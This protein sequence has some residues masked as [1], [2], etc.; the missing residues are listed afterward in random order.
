M[1]DQ[2]IGARWRGLYADACRSHALTGWVVTWDPPEYP[3]QGC[4]PPGDEGFHPYVLIADT[5]AEI[6]AR[7]PADLVRIGRRPAEPEAN[8]LPK[9]GSS[10][11]TQVRVI[12]ES[13]SSRCGIQRAVTST[14]HKPR[15]ETSEAPVESG[16]GAPQWINALASYPVETSEKSNI[17]ISNSPSN[18][19]LAAFHRDVG[20]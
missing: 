8:S 20:D 11:E 12:L 5:L 17:R 7:L 3:E 15:V 13:Q 9:P 14:A 10:S 18:S 4:R 1:A 16:E 2:V 6:H 19:L